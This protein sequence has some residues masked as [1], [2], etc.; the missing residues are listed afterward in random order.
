MKEGK[1]GGRKEGKKE[2]RKGEEERKKGLLHLCPTLGKQSRKG[3]TPL[4]EAFLGSEARLSTHIDSN[5][6]KM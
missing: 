3:M 6:S 2:R 1:K 4:P 5:Y